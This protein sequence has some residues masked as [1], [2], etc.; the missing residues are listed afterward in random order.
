MAVDGERGNDDA[1]DQLMR[2][3]FDN[4]S[5]FAGSGLAFVGVAAQINRFGGI[6]WNEAPLQARRK[7]SPTAAAKPAGFGRLDDVLRR[8]F[9][10]DSCGRPI[11][12]ELDISIDFLRTGVVIVL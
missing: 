12:T 3:L 9:L 10:Y 1:L 11:P 4:H 2:I 8:H 6:L 5:I 7:T